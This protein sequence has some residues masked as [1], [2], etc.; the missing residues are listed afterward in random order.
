MLNNHQRHYASRL[1]L[2]PHYASA[3][4]GRYDFGQLDLGLNAYRPDGSQSMYARD[5]FT[6]LAPQLLPAQ[7]HSAL[8]PSF[9]A[10]PFPVLEQHTLSHRPRH[11]QQPVYCPVVANA[12][13]TSVLMDDEQLA[14]M[15]QLSANFE[16]EVKV[17]RTLSTLLTPHKANHSPSPPGPSGQ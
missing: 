11:I 7:Q 8:A 1:G 12:A 2:Y 16:P 14:R 15:Q 5:E 3:L 13:C 6:H 17:S 4:P 9:A 10:S